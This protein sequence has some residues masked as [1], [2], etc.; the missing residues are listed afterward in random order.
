MS[1]I[2]AY[3]RLLERLKQGEIP[4]IIDIDNL[5]QWLKKLKIYFSIDWAEERDEHQ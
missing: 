2:D 3:I 5:I 4:S 1:K